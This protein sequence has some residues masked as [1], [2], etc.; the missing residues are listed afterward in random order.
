MVVSQTF[1]CF[2]PTLARTRNTREGRTKAGYFDFEKF[3]VGT[4]RVTAEASFVPVSTVTV[5]ADERVEHT[6]KMKFEGRFE[7]HIGI[8][9]EC[10]VTDGPSIHTSGIASEGVGA[11]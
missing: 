8:C 1:A 10:V 4:Y 7:A 2:S 5:A 3:P 6:V 9:A 11:R